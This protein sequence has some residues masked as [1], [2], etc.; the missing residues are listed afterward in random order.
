MKTIGAFFAGTRIETIFLCQLHI[1]TEE[2]NEK[3]TTTSCRIVVQR[4]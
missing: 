3:N 4:R 2:K 1:Q